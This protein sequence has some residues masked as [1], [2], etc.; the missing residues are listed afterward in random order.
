MY[1]IGEFSRI[2]NLTVTALRYYDEE[3]LLKPSYRADNDYRYYDDRD[4]QKA[5]LIAF[6]RD[7]DFSITELKDLLENVDGEEDL[8]FYLS[9]KRALIESRISRDHALM[10]K[11]DSLLKPVHKEDQHMEYQVQVKTLE[12]VTY[13][14]I[15]F[16]G[17]YSDV[18]PYFGKLFQAV[19][20]KAAGP[21]FCLYHDAG[22]EEAADIEAC[23]PTKGLIKLEG[24]T[25]GT[26]PRTMALSTIHIG[27]YEP[28]GLGY[29][30]LVDYANA[31]KIQAKLPSREIYLK[32]PG[33]IFAGNPAKYQT[34]LLF[35]Y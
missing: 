3:N 4:F 9:Q 27:S 30:A 18:G 19:K 7:L 35:P 24:F 17:K 6:L 25:S 21:A 12:P 1:K 11:I 33:M 10:A 28:V 5:R 2:T 20:G 23:V 15:R 32:G 34:E 8:P 29:K 31:H 16:K 14:G 26:L 13:L 22:C